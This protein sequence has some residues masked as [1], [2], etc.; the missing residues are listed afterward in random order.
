MF[1]DLEIIKQRLYFF[2]RALLCLVFCYYLNSCMFWAAKGDLSD[3]AKVLK[4]NDIN[5]GASLE[6]K[7]PNSN[8]VLHLAVQ[9]GAVSITNLL[10]RKGM[11]ANITSQ[12]EQTPLHV[13]AFHNK[14]S[15]VDILINA[16]AKINAVTKE[17]VT[18][19]HVASQRGNV[20]V[21]QQLLNHKANVNN[22]RF[23]IF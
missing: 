10:L 14:G 20:D 4:E 13:A 21:A 12:G 2:N 22:P 9:A 17:L 5:A 8:T 1:Y 23:I 15:I 11:N 7:M 3:L 6:E 16:G 18:P 19:L